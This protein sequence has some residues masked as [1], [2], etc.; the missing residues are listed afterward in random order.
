MQNPLSA[1]VQLSPIDRLD[2]A[3]AGLPHPLDPPVM[4]QQAICVCTRRSHTVSEM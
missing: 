4:I 2:G 1:G 3:M